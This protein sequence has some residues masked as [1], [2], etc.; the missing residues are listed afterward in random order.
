MYE[1]KS[2]SKPEVDESQYTPE[3]EFMEE[4]KQEEIKQA[5]PIIKNKIFEY[6]NEDAKRNKR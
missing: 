5:A 4:K 2:E 1:E 3:E 6:L